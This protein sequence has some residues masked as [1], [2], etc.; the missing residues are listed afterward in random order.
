MA[1]DAPQRTDNSSENMA[2]PPQG[3]NGRGPTPPNGNGASKQRGPLFMIFGGVVVLAG[4]A[5]GAYVVVEGGKS[6]STDNAYVEASAATVTSQVSAPVKEADIN[7]TKVVKQ[8]DVLVVL[9]DTDA[10]LALAGAQA[11]LDQVT[12]QVTGTYSNDTTLAAQQN[13]ATAQVASAQAALEKA[14]KGYDDRKT[15]A[16]I[17]AVSGED[18]T[19]AKVALDQA[20]AALNN[21]K[22][23]VAA[24]GGERAANAALISNVDVANSPQVKAAQ[25]RVE[26][27]QNDLDRTVIHAPIGGVVAKNTVQVGQR[28][29][30]GQALMSIVPI[31]AAYVN[32]NFKEVQL[33]K[34]RIGQPVVLTSDTYG[35]SVKFHGRVVGLSGG[36]GSA[37]AVIPA[38][39]ATGN[40]IKVVQRLPVRVSLDPKEL[41]KHPLRVGMSMTA[42]IDV[43]R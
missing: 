9:D 22:A 30:V 28:V 11:Q 29:S 41:E 6:V 5:Y 20:T 3:P 1:D 19:A 4:L 42:K 18:L 25:V 37:F 34:V 14:Q 13:A 12:R 40:W 16:D 39:N 31:D 33:K 17:G 15:L 43:T 26:Q 38:Q 8:G 7:D 35:S 27:A 21:A 23:Q 24:A 36:T 10:Q 32:A 2:P